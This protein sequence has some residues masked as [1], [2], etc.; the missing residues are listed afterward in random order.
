MPVTDTVEPET[1]QLPEAVN[2]TG[3]LEEATAVT[4]KSGSPYD[5]S[6]IGSKVIV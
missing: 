6:E 4:E 5:L 1:E 3:K 2:E